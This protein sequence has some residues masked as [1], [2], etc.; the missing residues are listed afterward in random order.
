VTATAMAVYNEIKNKKDKSYEDELYTGS[1]QSLIERQQAVRSHKYR[2]HC[3]SA[4]MGPQ[5]TQHR[6]EAL[7]IEDGISCR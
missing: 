5:Q 3:R 7:Y 2:Q 4:D 1:L 6:R